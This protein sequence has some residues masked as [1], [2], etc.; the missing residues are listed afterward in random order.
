[1]APTNRGPFWL[2]QLNGKHSVKNDVLLSIRLEPYCPTQYVFRCHVSGH[3]HGH[4]GLLFYEMLI[5]AQNNYLNPCI[6]LIWFSLT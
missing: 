2:H 3:D 6:L 1:M 5:S 4:C